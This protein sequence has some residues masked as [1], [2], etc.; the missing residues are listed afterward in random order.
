MALDR[1]FIKNF[2]FITKFIG[3]IYEGCN[4][5]DAIIVEQDDTLTQT[6]LFVKNS[7]ALC[8]SYDK[9]VRTFIYYFPKAGW[10]VYN[11]RTRQILLFNGS[12]W[13]P[14]YN[15]TRIS[16]IPAPFANELHTLS[17]EEAAAKSFSLSGSIASGEESNILLSVENIAQVAGKDFT[18]SGNTI[19]W[20][21]KGLDSIG[22]FA[23]DTFFVHYK[24]ANS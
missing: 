7:I 16:D 5:G 24:K 21:G 20:N 8:T 10:E 1:R 23:G 19:S 2:K 12:E 9:G 3:S 6:K 13:T 17:T 11:E 18:A 15:V 14:V 22:M 4:A